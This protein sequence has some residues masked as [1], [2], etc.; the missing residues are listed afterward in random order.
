MTERKLSTKFIVRFEASLKDVLAILKEDFGKIIVKKLANIVWHFHN[1][2]CI[3]HER[4]LRYSHT[5]MGHIFTT[6]AVI[7]NFLI[8]NNFNITDLPMVVE[9]V[10]LLQELNFQE[11]NYLMV[12]NDV[13]NTLISRLTRN[14]N[15]FVTFHRTFK[16]YFKFALP[17]S[18]PILIE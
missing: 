5:K 16:L 4:K 6:C 14:R 12:G 9:D 10:D 17:L 8:K 11:D 3:L 7:Q 2:R 1:S 13:R 15:W 18:R